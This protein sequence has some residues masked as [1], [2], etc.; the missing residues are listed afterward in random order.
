MWIKGL[1]QQNGKYI[2]RCLAFTLSYEVNASG[3]VRIPPVEDEF[4]VHSTIYSNK[5][6]ASH[7]KTDSRN[8]AAAIMR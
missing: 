3:A 5:Y 8:T 7:S 4:F 2:Q 1:G 6:I